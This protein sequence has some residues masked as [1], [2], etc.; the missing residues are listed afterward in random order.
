MSVLPACICPYFMQVWYPQW[1]EDG[2]RLP[3]PDITNDCSPQCGQLEL[4]M[5]RLEEQRVLSMAE[6]TP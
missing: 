1:L 2:V 6:S 4:N 3:G 5:G